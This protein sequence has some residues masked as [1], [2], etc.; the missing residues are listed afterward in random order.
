MHTP[1]M[2]VCMIVYMIVCMIVYMIVYM[3]VCMI[4]Y[5]THFCAIKN[6][7]HRNHIVMAK[8]KYLCSNLVTADG[9]KQCILWLVNGLC[10]NIERGG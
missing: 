2:I 9:L 5:M 7:L 1:Y 4:V 3:I 10:T 6:V 8:L